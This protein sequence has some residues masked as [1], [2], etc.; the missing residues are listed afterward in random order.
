MALKPLTKTPQEYADAMAEWLTCKRLT[1]F[2]TS[3][4]TALRDAALKGLAEFDEARE[5]VMLNYSL[6]I[7]TCVSKARA[8]GLCKNA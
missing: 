4:I 6:N 1:H 8:E 5:F 3:L 2:E 7:W